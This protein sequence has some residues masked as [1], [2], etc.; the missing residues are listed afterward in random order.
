M[1]IN[2]KKLGGCN[3]FSTE[4]L[5]CPHCKESNLHHIRTTIF[6]REEDAARTIVTEV[7]RNGA[8][9]MTVPSDLCDNPSSRRHGLVITFRCENCPAK[10]EMTLEQH[11]GSTFIAWRVKAAERLLVSERA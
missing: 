8:N 6:E 11:K 3:K 2:L 1:T 10:P 5:T 4:A 9:V 7:A